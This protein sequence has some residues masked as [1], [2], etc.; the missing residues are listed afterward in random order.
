MTRILLAVLMLGLWAPA[1]TKEDVKLAVKPVPIAQ[2]AQ[3][4]LLK[5]QHALDAI[6][7]RAAQLTQQYQGLIQQL[8][9]QEAAEQKLFEAEKAAAYKEAKVTPES[10]DLNLEKLEFEPKPAANSNNPGK[11]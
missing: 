3:V 6:R 4:K 9:M 1:Q 7:L 11:K 2:D 5:E 10:F 8:T